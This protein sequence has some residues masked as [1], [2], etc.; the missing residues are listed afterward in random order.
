L[1]W[2]NIEESLNRD[3]VR[4]GVIL[5][6]DEYGAALGPDER[7][8]EILALR[9]ED[10]KNSSSFY[11]LTP[12]TRFLQEV[13]NKVHEGVSLSEITKIFA[14]KKWSRWITHYRASSP[15]GSLPSIELRP[16]Q[17]DTG[18]ELRPIQADTGIGLRP[19]QADTTSAGDLQELVEDLNKRLAASHIFPS[20]SHPYD[21]VRVLMVH[22][23][24]D[25]PDLDV[26]SEL[27][28]LRGVF[29]DVYGFDVSEF[30]IDSEDPFWS[31]DRYLHKFLKNHEKRQ[32]II[33]VY[34]CHGDDTRGTCTWTG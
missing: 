30:K 7:G 1:N 10:W 34:N 3:S 21:T 13:M 5:E 32:L 20:G 25:D 16:I 18:I 12:T 28:D 17:A 4:L 33:F 9:R 19:I 23:D 29:K 27:D 15:G 2:S 31:L 14:E 24:H 6:C 22:W 26:Q 8:T 11:D